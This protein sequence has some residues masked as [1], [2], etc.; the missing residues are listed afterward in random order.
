MSSSP[1]LLVFVHAY[2]VSFTQLYYNF[3]TECSV[4]SQWRLSWPQLL[5]VKLISREES[6]INSA[7]QCD[8][9]WEVLP[10]DRSRNSSF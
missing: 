5:D 9:L 6:R 7:N 2:L 3:C 4:P 10:V 8:Y 1:W